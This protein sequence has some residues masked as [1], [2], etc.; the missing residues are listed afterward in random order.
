MCTRWTT[1]ALAVVVS[2]QA[3]RADDLTVLPDGIEGAPAK[4]MLRRHLQTRAEAAFVRRKET[5]ETLKSPEDVTA[6]QQ[7]MRAFL[8]EQLGEFP[9]RTPL[10]ARQVGVIERDDCTVEK[11]VFESRPRFYVTGNLYRPR[12]G[13]PFPGVIV[14]C[15]HTANG[16]AADA[17]Q[18]LC[19]LLAR[20]GIVALCYDP[21]GQ[22]ERY[23]LLDDGKPS[24]RSTDEHTYVGVGSILVGRSTAHYRIWDGIRALDYLA[25]RDDVDPRR[26]GCTGNSGGGTLTQYLMAIDDRIRCAV[27]S[28][29]VTTFDRRLATN[30]IGDAE[31]NVFGQIA[32]GLDHAD[33]TLMR[34]PQPTLYGTA[35]H[36]FVDI[37]G[38]WDIFRESKRLYTRLGYAERIDLIEVDGEHGY[39]RPKREAA[40]RWLRRWL[41][42]VDEP[43]TE[44]EF[45]T[46]DTR[47]LLCTPRGQVNLIDGARTV[48]DLNVELA[49]SFAQ[50]RSQLWQDRV[51]ALARVGELAGVRPL[52][53]LSKAEPK[54]L[55]TL[56]REGHR[57]E[58]LLFTPEPGIV[59][60]ALLFVPTTPNGERVLYL[61][62]EGQDVH[63]GE[64]ATITGLVQRGQTVLAVDLRGTGETGPSSRG[65]WGGGW[66][67]IWISYLLGDSLT[68]KRAEDTLVTARWFAG[69]NASEP[70]GIRVLARDV[71]TIPA[72]HAAALDPSPFAELRLVGMPTTWTT[73]LSA[74]DTRGQ[75][76]NAV[77]GALRTY[78][79]PD[80][81]DAARAAGIPVETR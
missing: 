69:W 58:R 44:P 22:G 18:R 53:E 64:S 35:T 16:K 60:P 80:L 67:E 30:T 76:V 79:L 47:D 59:L 12:T 48:M 5:Y 24:H 45:A 7:R 63:A 65:V 4:E 11:I 56:E 10:D 38:A 51:A 29:C 8:L 27:P 31:Q 20:N 17:Y 3:T 54:R 40:V 73:V 68:G 61:D 19:I 72:L 6:Y 14:P 23:Q 62:G 49:E 34:A 66:N 46:L 36:D 25:S 43:I 21:I 77:H 2:L 55:G 37:A 1:L 57:I 28:C 75:L 9:E 32:F 41:N 39:S 52:N 78:D 71:T 74:A 50:E 33:Y 26:L 81:V 15:G 42:G 70:V 13:G